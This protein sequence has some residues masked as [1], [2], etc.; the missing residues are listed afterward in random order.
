M[1]KEKRVAAI[2]DLSGAGKC[3]LTIVLP[4]MSALGC[5]VSVLPTALLS[6][7]TGGFT[8]PVVRD[9][10]ADLL[11]MA[12]HWKKEGAC[13]EAVYSGFLGSADQ[14]DIVREIFAMNRE[15]N[16]AV[17]I[18]VDP[19]MGDHGK[20]YKTY[21]KEMA[22]GM[23]RL[24]AGADIIVPNMTEAYHLLGETYK[25]GPYDK[26]EIE[27]MLRALSDLGPETV[28][29]TG[30]WFDEAKIGAACYDRQTDRAD[31]VLHPRVPG[32]YHGTGDLFASILLGGL[33]QGLSLQDA[34]GCAVRGVAE[35]IRH[36]VE[37]GRTDTRWGVR[38]EDCLFF[39]M[40]DVFSL[41][42]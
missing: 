10:T 9:L 38:F 5:E 29:L 15:M 30:V 8:N 41:A 14:I 26:A 13:F 24:C 40:K 36:T 12:E 16:P 20:L 4:V 35:C 7:H 39:L 25:A 19:V 34:C 1:T 11:P 28:V 23:A 32:A 22:D 33:M 21:T 3:A 42:K 17:K 37:S 18:L 6:T 31:F 2:H 27:R